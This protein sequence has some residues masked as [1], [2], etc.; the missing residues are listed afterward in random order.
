[1]RPKN[2]LCHGATLE[3]QGTPLSFA[4]VGDRVRRLGRGGHDDQVDAV[5]EDQVARHGARAVRVRLRV[6]D[7]DRDL[8]LALLGVD[9]AGEAV[10]DAV[11]DEAVR[12]GERGERAGARRHVTDLEIGASAAP[13]PAGGAVAAVVV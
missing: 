4:L 10:A 12:L 1:L 6:L 5:L 8:A 3:M 9:P 7:D 13:A 2:Q 11:E